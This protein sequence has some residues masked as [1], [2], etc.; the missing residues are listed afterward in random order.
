MIPD[1]MAKLLWIGLSVLV[2]VIAALL[3]YMHHK[4]GDKSKLML[5]LAFLISI[6]FY[7]SHV[8]ELSA[9]IKTMFSS[10][11]W[12]QIPQTISVLLLALTSL[13]PQ[14]SANKSFNAFLC[15]LVLS[16]VM[17]IVPLS[18]DSIAV[19]IGT[20]T[21]LSVFAM[22]GY[23]ILKRRNPKDCLLL[24]AVIN[25]A[26]MTAGESVDLT[27]SVFSAFI[28][29]LSLLLIFVSSN[30]T[31]VKQA[32]TSVF[33]LR[34]ELSLT[35]EKLRISEEERVKAQRLATIGEMATMIAHD[36]RNPLQSMTFASDVLQSKYGSQIDENGRALI[37][38]LS[39]SILKSEKIVSDLLDYSR[40]IRI[41]PN[42]TNPKQLIESA[43]DQTKPP[44][45]VKVVDQTEAQ[46]NLEADKEKIERVFVNIIKN[47][48]DAMPSGG[49]LTI[50]SEKNSDC[51]VFHFTDTGV[52]MSDET[53]SKLW[54]PLFTTKAQ[55]MGFGTA[56]CK[57]IVESHG[58]EIAAKSV[59]NK[60]TTFSV[61]LPLKL[62]ILPEKGI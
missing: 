48:Y 47:A 38:N 54:T 1:Q 8:P 46:P 62:N 22:L 34:K 24:I 18:T 4:D 55:G 33:S 17:M 23:S 29:N 56:I 32:L 36:L 31:S 9:L 5:C 53:M 25:F 20:P 15:F 50:R 6:P 19:L 16:I 39:K 58:G 52:G 14:N 11:M 42:Q 41:E 57:R 3:L 28:G 45:H 44:V 59:V 35:K 37:S 30:G 43:L 49:N 7:L 27:F 2:S 10:I 12:A 21:G 51:V 40:E 13:R 26:L 60:G 61:K